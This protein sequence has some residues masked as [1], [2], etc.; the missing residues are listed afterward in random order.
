MSLCLDVSMQQNFCIFRQLLC[1][2]SAPFRSWWSA[3]IQPFPLHR[4]CPLPPRPQISS[5]LLSTSSQS[6]SLHWCPEHLPWS[7]SR[8]DSFLGGRSTGSLKTD[9]ETHRKQS[10][11]FMRWTDSETFKHSL[12]HVDWSIISS[13]VC[14]CQ[15]TTPGLRVFSCR[16]ATHN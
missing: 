12:P 1:I 9:A 2:L 4:S 13:Q 6:A 11:G 3:S 8:M 5:P 7:V 15:H 14:S 10:R 16:A